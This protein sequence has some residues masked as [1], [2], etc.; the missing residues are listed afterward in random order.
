MI[1]NHVSKD[2]ISTFSFP[3]SIIYEFA[4]CMF[5]YMPSVTLIVPANNVLTG[6]FC[7]IIMHSLCAL[8][9]A[10]FER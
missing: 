1:S 8:T 6:V 5:T 7:R 9:G 10:F 2:A 3:F 4:T